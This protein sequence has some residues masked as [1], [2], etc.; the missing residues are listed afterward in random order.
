MDK[1]CLTIGACVASLALAALM[2]PAFGRPVTQ[3][4][5]DACERAAIY[6]RPALAARE[7]EAWIANCLADATAGSPPKKGREY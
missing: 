1:K 4:Q 7:K 3:A 2:T 5:R 6:V